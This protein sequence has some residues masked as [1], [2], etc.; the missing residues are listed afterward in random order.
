MQVDGLR[1]QLRA[2]EDQILRAA[3]ASMGAGGGDIESAM[4][5]RKVPAELK[6]KRRQLKDALRAATAASAQGGQQEVEGDSATSTVDEAAVREEYRKAMRGK[7]GVTTHDWG[8]NSFADMIVNAL[9]R[10]PAAIEQARKDLTNGSNQTGLRVFAKFAGI[11]LP[12]SQRDQK[13]AIDA[14]AGITP[15][16]RASSDKVKADTKASQSADKSMKSA[17]SG[18]ASVAM[19]SPD[20][21]SVDGAAWVDGLIAEGYT[22]IVQRGAATHLAKPDGSGYRMPHKAIA[23]YARLAAKS[24]A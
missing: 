23:A 18:A 11:T 20:G 4:R 5:S 16:Q 17:R 21:K 14:W 1:A 22:V 6:T 24:A 9:K 15:E 3:P 2:V 12:R 19:H 13:A 10:D 7:T 8:S